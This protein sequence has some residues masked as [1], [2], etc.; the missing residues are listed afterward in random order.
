MDESAPPWLLAET[1]ATEVKKK[2]PVRG[3]SYVVASATRFAF[4]PVRGCT[5]RREP[6]SVTPDGVFLVIVDK[7]ANQKK[8]ATNG[9]GKFTLTATVGAPASAKNSTFIEGVKNKSR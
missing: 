1:P 7:G 2:D 4:N 6:R 3:H 5:A 8:N 9:A